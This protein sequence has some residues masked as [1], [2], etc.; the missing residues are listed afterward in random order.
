[1]RGAEYDAFI[2]RFVAA[3]KSRWPRAVLQWEDLSKDTAFSVLDRHRASLASFNDDVQGTGAMA[4]AGVIAAC[5][6]RG[7][8][9]TDQ[10]IV[11][12]GAGAGGGGVAQILCQGLRR[13]GLSAREAADC[14]WL[15]DSKGLIIANREMEPYKRQFARRPD[16]LAGWGKPDLL[17]TI[18]RVRPTV[19][20]GLSGQ[21]GVFD[22]ITVKTM[23]AQV[24][25]PVI[26]PLSNPTTSTEAMPADLVKWTDGKVIMAT[27]SPFAPVEHAGGA[28]PVPQGNNAFIFPGLGLGSIL[29]G[30]R[31]ITDAMV[32]AA[33]DALASY[34]IDKHGAAGRVYPPV[35][36]LGEVSIQVATAVVRTAIADGVADPRDPESIEAWVR[37][38]FW[39]PR[40]LPYVRAR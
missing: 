5:R 1:M 4:L 6:L 24:D 18:R 14:L 13:E 32:L 38:K 2:E 19:L 9:L 16:D 11:I 17:E 8:R 12:H 20:L 22:E 7:E 33:A 31:S 25:R 36:E 29:S 35:T 39:R 37:S 10:R 26:F 40:Y 21:P 28:I 3:I 23:A 15:L 34:T 30:A 27:G